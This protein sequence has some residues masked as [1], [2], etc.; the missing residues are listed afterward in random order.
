[1]WILTLTTLVY[2]IGVYV[3]ASEGGA[4]L[5]SSEITVEVALNI[6]TV[7]ATIWLLCGCRH[8]ATSHVR[9]TDEVPATTTALTPPLMTA[10][11]NIQIPTAMES[12][13]ATNSLAARI[14]DAYNYNSGATDVDD[15]LC[16]YAGCTYENACNYNPAAYDL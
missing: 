6:A 12:S 4:L 10:L 2:N 11:V 9:G 3:Y 1:M 16:V 7:D 5:A 15:S 8:L 14:E 13:I